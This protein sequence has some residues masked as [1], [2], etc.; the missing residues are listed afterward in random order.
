MKTRNELPR[1]DASNFDIMDSKSMRVIVGGGD[2]ATVVYNKKKKTQYG[3]VDK[4]DT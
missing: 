1:I 2:C 4:G 3:K